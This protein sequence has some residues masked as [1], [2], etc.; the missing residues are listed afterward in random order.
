MLAQRLV[1]VLCEHCREPYVPSEGVIREF[2]FDKLQSG[3]VRLYRAVGCEHCGGTGY[4]GRVGII[5]ML[6][7]SDKIREL[8]LQHAGS[9]KIEQAAREEGMHSMFEDGCLKALQGVT[10]IEEVVRVTQEA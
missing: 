7:M 1:R 10:T 8:V 5:E 9:G 2:G 6:P 3:E 4:R